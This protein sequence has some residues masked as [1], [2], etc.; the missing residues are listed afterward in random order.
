MC[1]KPS[2]F[3]RWFWLLALC[4]LG[5]VS[6]RAYTATGKSWPSGTVTFQLALG[7]PSSTL[8]DGSTSWDAVAAD[9]LST[10]NA[11]LGRIQFASVS[12][13]SAPNGQNNGQ[14]NVT[15]SSTVYG[16]GFG[17]NV[18]AVTVTYSF[19][20][21]HVES[22]VVFNNASTWDSY[23]GAQ[24]TGPGGGRIEDLYRV[25]L[26]ELGH[27]LGLNHPDQAGQSVSA[28]MNS[29]V[30]N[31]DS[32]TTDD[33]TGVQSIYGAVGGSSAPVIT[34]QPVAQSVAA[35]ANVTFTVAATGTPSPT[36]Q[37]RKDGSNLAG[38]TSSSLSL[39]NVQSSNAGSY[40]VVVSNSAGSVTSNAVALTVS[41]PPAITTQPVAQSVSAGAN[42][43]FTVAAT[44]TPS[45]T[46]Q[47]R[48]DGSNLA[49]AT[50]SSL[51]LTNVQ[52]SNAGSYSVVVS[53]SAGSVTSNA[54]ALT[55]SV[56]PAITTQ[57]VA[58]SVNAGANVTFTVAATGTPSPTYQWRK[59]GSNLPG[60][61]SSSL[62]LTNVQSS[63]AGSY[64]VV[65]TNSAGSVTSNAV[66]LTVSV[67]P[68]ITTQPVAQSV[69]A[70][71]SVTFTVAASGTPSPT[72]QWRKDGT[73]L[74]GAT[75]ASLALSNVQSS[76]AGSYSVVV[77]NSAG[78]VT[79]NAVALTVSVPPAITTQ[80]VAQS[81]MAGA[82]VT[83]LVAA[84]GTPAPTFQWRKD[85]SNLAGATSASLSLTSVQLSNAGSYSVVVSNSAGSVTSTAV[86]L[87]VSAAPVITTQP[88]AQAVTTGAN[89][90]FTVV[91]T[92]N[93][94]PSFQWHQD[95]ANIP[96]ATNSTFSLSNV[97][98]TS[99]GNY[100]VVVSNIH[101]SVTSTS[102]LL[103]VSSSPV[104]TTQPVAQAVNAGASVTFSVTAT[105]S[106]APTYQWRRDGSNLPGATNASLTLPAVQLSD[107]G[108]F[109]VVVTN[110][111]GSVTSNAVALTV[112][113]P[114]SISTQPVAQSVTAGANV[115]F[116]VTA[117]G[118]PS[119]TFQWRKDGTNL[120]GATSSTLT[121]TSVQSSN[122]GSYSVVVSNSAGNVTSN[123]VALTV[124]PAPAAPVITTQPVAQSVTAGANVTFTVA[125]TGT[126]TPTFQ[127]RKDG[128]NLPGA[129]STS[130]TL[131]SVQLSDAGSF[132]VVASNASGSV[133]S[134][135]VA[136]TVAPAPAA[137]VITTQPVA[138]SVTAGANV[139]FTVAAT[140][141]P[142]PTFQWRKDGTNLPGATSAS[143]TLSAVQLSDA[144]SF[145]VVAS[146]ASGS[147]TSNAVAL[148]VAPAPAA[149]VIT[150]QP[151]AQSVTAGANVTFTVS[152]TGTPAPTFQWRKDGSNL[153]GAT[154]A[155]LT[156]SSVQLSD[157]GSFSVVASNASGS[158][159]SNA[160][161]L[162]VAPA[163]AAP[164]ITTQPVAQ[165]V[166]AGAN[167]T[168]TVAATGTPAP[169][170]Q[171]RK[172]GTNL[173]GAT[174]AS[175]TL[176][177]V[178]LSDAGSFSVVASNASGSVTSNAVALTVAPAPA[179]PVITTQPVAQSVTAGANVTFTVAATG[180]PAPTFQWRK[181]GTNLPGATSASLT[182]SAVQ[183][184][185][186]GS[187]SVVAS[188]ASGSVTS[189]AVALT[190]A[191]APAAPVITTQ[192]VA[193]SVTAG[194]NVTFTVAATGTPAPTFQWRKDGSNLPGA[195]GA[196]LTLSSVQLSDAGSF[197]VVAS[198]ASGSVASNAAALT[199]APAPAA[200]VLVAQPLSQSVTVGVTVTFTVAATGTPTPT[201]Q[202]RKDGTNLSG[203]TSASLTLSSVQL[204][205]AGS[206]SVVVSNPLGTATSDAAFLTVA[207]AP[208][209]P[210]ITTQPASQSVSVGTSVTFTV[211]ASGTPAPGFQWHKDGLPLP[212]ATSA[213]LTLSSVQFSDAGSYSAVAANA[214]GSVS[215]LAAVLT[216]SP[217][218]AAPVITT[219]PTAQSVTVGANLTFTVAASGTPAPTY[220]WR[221]DGVA[222]PGATL[223]SLALSSVQLSDTGTFSVVVSNPSGSVT[224]NGASLTVSPAPAA[225]VITTQPLSQSVTSGATVTFAVAAT[226]TPAP[227]FQWRKDGAA[228]PG[229]TSPSLTLPAVQLGNA[230][231][232][233]VTVSN[234]S[235]T[236]SSHPATLTVTPA[237]EPPQI[238][239]QPRSQE[240]L[241]GT[242]VTFTVT[243]T[244]T[245]TLRYQW[246]QNGVSIPGATS[247][248]LQL[249]SVQA[250]EAGN[251][252]VVVTND[253]G[254]ITSA[255]ALLSISQ[256]T[257]APSIVRP[258]AS[259]EVVQRSSLTLTVT[260]AGTAPFTYQWA[261]NGKSLPGETRPDL[262]IASVAQS[263]AGNYTVT[264]TNAAGSVTSSPAVIRVR[265]RSRL[266][267][268]SIRTQ[269]GPG[270]NTLI[271]GFVSNG[272]E[273]KST[274]IRSIGPTLAQ[275]G[276]PGAMTDPQLSLFRGSTQVASNDN[277]SD[278][279]TV[280]S[281]HSQVGAFNLPPDSRDAALW[282]SLPTGAYTAQVSSADGT[283]G[284]VLME[285][286]DADSAASSSNLINLSARSRVGSGDAALIAGLVVQ[287]DGPKRFLIRAIGP[288]LG[289]FGVDGVLANPSL[290]LISNGAVVAE[291][292]DWSGS[293]E[294]STAF[295]EVGA[296]PLPAASQ[297][298]VVVVTLDPGSYTA[299][300]S[301]ANDTSGIALLELYELP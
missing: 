134:N 165:S 87:T 63:N 6:A 33:I 188:N 217:A 266:I 11:Y 281:T 130:L 128:T 31:T 95:G 19:F 255:P 135:A 12:G 220:Q 227:T 43:T 154:G 85:G 212:G 187:F 82:N 270:D 224:S 269:A 78:S 232:Y 222:I 186:A 242:S 299:V 207:P 211:A 28:I 169:T 127:W 110:S 7:T 221:K 37:W 72:Y 283:N 146:N 35:G 264:V 223:P 105:G 20:N 137:P 249:A 280:A 244:G 254:S 91:A 246:R 70:G 151:V 288:T 10:W 49:G 201:F 291:N 5:T 142:A 21:T 245:P 263:D 153:P 97:Q 282:L 248:S 53:N 64:S 176:S 197:S 34:T 109:S 93:P 81:V 209:E 273:P 2:R 179:A 129:T 29:M 301:G 27:S 162:T 199:V 275:F 206:F 98:L 208:A 149:P 13:S 68:A 86:A 38:A 253:Q 62:S 194:A 113:V 61:T 156:L 204:S 100:S 241:A 279:S 170:F 101:G 74:S 180:T 90:T 41:V 238:T 200:P 218:P 192:P 115:T 23:R 167:V 215:S 131:S 144:G 277:W 103:T 193:Q 181:D 132:S 177:A 163:P 297:D 122:A 18:L 140:G 259:Q 250:T 289:T 17:A 262:F 183:L 216:V 147:V 99:A 243:A 231:T 42:V 26:H 195:T 265:S 77:S 118:T 157:A 171:W 65:V 123:A 56:P 300:V 168:F 166:T 125:A 256:S 230:G 96:G 1:S 48:K 258:P 44:G 69:T 152:A 198:N 47:W 84:T 83:F 158:V 237:P 92:G 104:I 32:L 155:S 182:L 120:P 251:Y 160:V 79:S 175:L 15:F 239:L 290:R 196:S 138:Q 247:A 111:A 294:L 25:A 292:D 210:V 226:G 150:T 278:A 8:I 139:T 117:T 54:V 136:L 257:I 73:D 286:Y 268:L 30:S 40:S 22:D 60:A 67:P 88:A 159:T 236:V 112:S 116:T 66:A 55:I 124:A 225:P 219:Q 252:T 228:L 261:R 295:A 172:D 190:V 107:A 272:T 108:S 235:G 114:P 16:S 36:Y 80:P 126:P 240:V 267:N 178:Q 173:P 58:Q 94:S 271:V 51:S 260:V 164:V 274:L 287:G 143:L 276:V 133:T 191:P 76:H 284:V 24:R 184:S 39:T 75:S 119:P 189:N 148:T 121:L 45:P 14:N 102:A 298:A 141:T 293:A 9:A 213:S 4:L 229:A 50:S 59:D 296:F 174:S 161:A 185:D 106:P 214:S 234:L 203:A 202:W 145:S 89:V 71:A 52:S 233:E 3:V 46:Y 57:P 205:D 285:V